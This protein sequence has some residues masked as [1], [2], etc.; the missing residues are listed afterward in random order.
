M[1]FFKCACLLNSLNQLLLAV[2][3]A[4]LAQAEYLTAGKLCVGKMFPCLKRSLLDSHNNSGASF[5]SRTHQMHP[6]H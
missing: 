2:C 4:T 5:I 6:R 3:F 1:P